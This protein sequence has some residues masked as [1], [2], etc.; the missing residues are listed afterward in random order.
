MNISTLFRNAFRAAAV[1]ALAGC[2]DHAVSGPQVRASEVLATAQDESALQGIIDPVLG[3]LF[4]AKAVSR[5]VPLAHDIK[6]SKTIGKSGGYLEIPQAGFRLEVPRG[7]VKKNTVFTA[8]AVAGYVIAYEFTPEGAVFKKDLKI[9]Q[10]LRG[11]DWKQKGFK[12]AQGGYFSSRDLISQVQRLVLTLELIPA[13]V[14]GGGDDD[15]DDDGP[16]IKFNVKHFSG[17]MVSGC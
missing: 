13:S 8:T 17:Y 10:S 12:K 15:D 7:A 3:L 2:A 6:V 16:A 4:P 5:L 14:V 1:L 9:T 11:T